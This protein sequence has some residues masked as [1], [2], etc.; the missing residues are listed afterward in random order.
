MHAGGI[1]RS[2]CHKAVTGEY[3]FEIPLTIII[4]H[5]NISERFLSIHENVK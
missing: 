2:T 1:E 5:N 3:V 4:K